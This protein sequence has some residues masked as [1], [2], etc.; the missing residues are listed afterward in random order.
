LATGSSLKGRHAIAFEGPSQIMR[1]IVQVIE[2]RRG[3]LETYGLSQMKS[4]AT[5]ALGTRSPPDESARHFE[6]IL[7]WEELIR[8]GAAEA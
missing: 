1:G 5:T 3:D 7:G 4:F 2:T 8:H 6:A